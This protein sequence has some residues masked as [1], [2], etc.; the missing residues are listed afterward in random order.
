MKK[1]ARTL[2]IVLVIVLILGILALYAYDVLVART[3]YTENL[4]KM[5][6][7]VC[8]LLG[9]LVRLTR[10][11]SRRSLMI[12]EKAYDRELGAAFHH[13]PLLRKKLLCAC[14]LYNE[15]NFKKALKYLFA[16]LKEAEFQR[17]IIPVYLFIALCFEDGGAPAEAVRAY[18]EILKLDPKN[19]QVQ[20]NLGRLHMKAGDFEQARSHFDAAIALEPNYYPVYVNR[21]D[22]YFTVGDYDSAVEDLRKALEIKNNGVEA[23]DL[24]T[25]IYAL[26]GDEENKKKYYSLSLASGTNPNNLNEAI[27]YYL[28]A[29]KEQ[30]GQDEQDSAAPEEGDG[31]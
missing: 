29:Q 14:R 7:V 21:G 2:W 13:K 9:T 25:I 12:Y 6:A 17:D 28:N 8:M 3:P 31:T 26:R 15:R 20:S 1:N 10:G 24:L 16:L 27:A 30:D 4:F 22:Y 19:V 23:S 18:Y 5:I 11:Q